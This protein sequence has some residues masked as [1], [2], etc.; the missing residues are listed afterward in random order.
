MLEV[1]V[2]MFPAETGFARVS[3][4]RIRSLCQSARRIFEARFIDE[5]I[6]V[7]GRTRGGPSVKALGEEW[8]LQEDG[9]QASSLEGAVDLT[10]DRQ[11]CAV[12]EL[13]SDASHLE[14]SLER[15]LETSARGTPSVVDDSG[16]TMELRTLEQKSRV[17][18]VEA[19]TRD[20]WKRAENVDQRTVGACRPGCGHPF[21]D[22]VRG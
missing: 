10:E 1:K 17:G 20:V 11:M 22:S 18:H 15:I 4:R 14:R 21:V 8:P 16:H 9:A 13:T 6:D 12:I 2:V 3:R 5:Q 7:A 19:A